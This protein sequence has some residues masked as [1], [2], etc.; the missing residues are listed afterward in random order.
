MTTATLESYPGR[1]RFGATFA[2]ALLIG[3]LIAAAIAPAVAYLLAS[4]GLR[5]PFPRIF[6]RVAM[7][8]LASALLL[9][10][11]RLCLSKLLIEG[12]HEP[13]ANLS[14]LFAGLGAA[15]IGTLGSKPSPSLSRA[16]AVQTV[17]TPSSVIPHRAVPN[18]I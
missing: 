9:F 1:S 7:V 8:T 15:T 13:R 3:A 2:I 18:S 11:R 16:V 4:A 14:R 6:D 10:A 5:F 17:L 12:F